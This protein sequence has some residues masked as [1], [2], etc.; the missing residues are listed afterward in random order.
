MPK[1]QSPKFKEIICNVPIDVLSTCSTLPR[2]VDSNALVIFKMK[3]KLE[4]RGHVYSNFVHPRLIF[5]I[6]QF[7]NRTTQCIMT[8]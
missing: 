2:P 1:G 5:R 3:R 7:W 4:C 8:I 6:L